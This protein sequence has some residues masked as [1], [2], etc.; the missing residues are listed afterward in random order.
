MLE[1]RYDDV[2]CRIFP[3]TLEGIATRWHHSLL[4]N[5]IHGWREFKKLFLEKFVNDKTLVVLLK[6]L[7]NIKMGEK[8]RFNDFNQRFN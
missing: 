5:L 1:V 4:I 3:F 6:E 2:T 7:Q 8:E